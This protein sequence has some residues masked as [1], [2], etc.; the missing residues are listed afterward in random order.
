MATPGWKWR[1]GMATAALRGRPVAVYT[2]PRFALEDS[3]FAPKRLNK[4]LEREGRGYQQAA[5]FPHVVIND[6]VQKAALRTVLKEFEGVAADRWKIRS[7]DTEIKR[8]NEDETSFG[9]YTWKLI[10]TLNSSVFLTFLERLTG[11][12]GLIADPH[13][14]GGGLHDIRRGGKLNVHADFNVHR[15]LTLYRRLNLLLY[16]NRGWDD[17]WGGQLELWDRELTRCVTR[18]PPVFNRAVIFNT[19]SHSYHGHPT[20]LACPDDRSRM[21]VALYYYTVACPPGT[22]LESHTT[23]FQSLPGGA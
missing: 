11:I 13:L 10:H 19:T 9:P 16:L 23:V 2:P 8:S 5:P 3:F 18:V 6:F 22:A 14:R 15:R 4:V 12:D 1:V 21:S 17:T 20:P 7:R